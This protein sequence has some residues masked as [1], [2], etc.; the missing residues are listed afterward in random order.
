M[1]MRRIATVGLA[2]VLTLGS[3][4]TGA[5]ADPVPDRKPTA[6]VGSHDIFPGAQ[7]GGPRTGPL[8]TS[9]PGGV[10]TQ[11]I[12]TQGLVG[13]PFTGFTCDGTAGARVEVLYVREATMP[14]RYAALHP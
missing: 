6:V 7:I 1:I 5:A 2:A 14:D 3:A 4:A 9:V 12:T 8:A 10:T 13:G 11:G